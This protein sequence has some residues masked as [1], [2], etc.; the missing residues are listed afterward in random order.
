MDPTRV[1]VGPVSAF[2]EKSRQL[3]K[4]GNR[5]IA[6]YRYGGQFFALDNACYHHGG[7]LLEGDIEDMGGH[8]C[9]VCPWHQY[10][11][12]LDT[13][14]GLYWALQMLPNGIP[15]KNAP[16]VVRSKGRKQRTHIVTIENDEVY[17]TVNTS[18]PRVD[19]DV[20]A[21]MA[22]AN[23]EK[24]MTMPMNCSGCGSMKKIH[25]GLRSGQVFAEMGALNKMRFPGSSEKPILQCVK[26]EN[27]CDSTKKFY[28]NICQGRLEKQLIPGQFVDLKLP[29]LDPYGNP[30]V[31]RW[32]VIDTNKEG[33][34]FTLII[35]AANES[36]GGS[37]WMFSN[38]LH[39]QF[40]LI[41]VGGNFTF[42]HHMSRLREIEGR[43]VILSAGIGITPAYASLCRYF[44]EIPEKE[45]PKLHVLHLHVDR[46]T[47]SVV[48]LQKYIQWHYAKEVHFT[49]RFQ[50]YLTKQNSD[51]IMMN[52]SL[53]AI[54]VC[55]RR[56]TVED[57][58][59]FVR[60]FVSASPVLAFVSGPSIFV[61][62]GKLALLSLGV[63]ESDLLTDEEDYVNNG[64]GVKA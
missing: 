44:E 45:I 57:I 24:A 19:S 23:Q 1:H 34:L 22:L 35:K 53:R 56:P 32:T 62:M 14:E 50:C 58:H 15:D 25:S 12:T 17:V 55:G 47:S 11:I 37:V 52:E 63:L 7:P 39:Q 48:G 3:V 20:Y 13:G 6:V 27:L 36:R 46:T 60:E 64:G 16:Q 5:N 21:E 8:P 38:A 26:V 31:R 61:S 43:I 2:K 18:E 40:T 59:N 4:S 42:T 33:S 49:Y 54:T 28:F 9:I 51:T 29:F 10:H 30:F 41:R